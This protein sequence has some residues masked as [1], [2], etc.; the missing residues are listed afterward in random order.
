MNLLYLVNYFYEG[1][2]NAAI[3][4]VSIIN[5]K[6]SK[7]ILEDYTKNRNNVHSIECYI[8]KHTDWLN[9]ILKFQKD[10]NFQNFTFPQLLYHYC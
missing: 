2:R 6:Y 4:Y 10:F 9:D 3:F 1:S 8:S 5:M 7:D